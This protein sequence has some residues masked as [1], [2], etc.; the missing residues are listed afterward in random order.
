[1]GEK[2][3]IIIKNKNKFVV[4]KRIY[5][6]KT[7]R[8][9]RYCT[10]KS[11]IYCNSW[12]MMYLMKIMKN[13]ALRVLLSVIFSIVFVLSCVS[14]GFAA[15]NGTDSAAQLKSDEVYTALKSSD[16]RPL[17]VSKYGDT[18]NYPENSKEAI[19]A[20]AEIGADMIMVN[21]KKTADSYIVLMTDENL[22][23]MCVDEV[24]NAVN[25]NISEV[26]YHEI[27]TYHLRNSTGFLH[28][29]ITEYTVPTLQEALGAL[30]DKG[31]LLISGGWGF[32]DD[33]YKLLSDENAL[34]RAVIIANGDKKE[35]SEWLAGKQTMPLVM[36]DNT[37][38]GS[39][40]SYSS[41]TLS[42]GAVSVLLSAKNPYSSIFKNSVQS[43]FQDSGRSAIDMTNPDLCGGR[44][45]NPEGWN[46]VAKCGF[47]I[48]IT[49][50][51]EGLLA[52]YSRVSGYREV[53]TSKITKAQ[54]IDTTLCSTKS[55]NA[56]KD[57]IA[58]AKKVYVSSLSENEL[59]QSN[60]DLSLAMSALTNRTDENGGKTV[61]TGRI[62]AVV[63]VVIFLI[64]LEIVFETTRRKKVAKR[65]AN[66]RRAE[67]EHGNENKNK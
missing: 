60:Y 61:T 11:N 2:F 23:R 33:I 37:D 59:M 49:N 65:N 67:R 32:R 7:I 24:G 42:A 66:D 5:C 55:A 40:K 62:I 53:L 45:D 48:I 16:E 30:S 44:D 22:S 38:N 6:K 29:K 26:G 43:K 8:E 64:V 35:V 12:C 56:L 57:A 13:K 54:N 21:V 15:E 3:V 4:L 28:E 1:M 52:Y 63:A 19:S 25:K 46:S 50:N 17:C 51:T 39:A 27:S 41:K 9:E 31:L 14:V 18:E 34:N 47:S 20:A 58:D 10:P 36:S